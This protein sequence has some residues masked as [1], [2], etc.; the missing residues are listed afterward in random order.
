MWS[1][2]GR[3]W[4]GV[5]RALHSAHGYSRYHSC[6]LMSSDNLSGLSSGVDANSRSSASHMGITGSDL[7]L[8]VPST[9]CIG[10]SIQ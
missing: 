4:P 3:T 8:R 1:N 7:R 10:T 2:H 9:P 6:A 5:R